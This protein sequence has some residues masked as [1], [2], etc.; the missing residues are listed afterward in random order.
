M[1]IQII[2]FWRK[3]LKRKLWKKNKPDI[4]ETNVM[5]WAWSQ[6]IAHV[7]QR[8]RPLR[9][10]GQLEINRLKINRF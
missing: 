9:Y 1:Y 3:T 4:K 2:K 5:P 10:R 8:S 6:N 7:R